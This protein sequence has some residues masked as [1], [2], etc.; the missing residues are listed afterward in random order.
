MTW[1]IIF[2]KILIVG[3]VVPDNIVLWDHYMMHEALI[4]ISCV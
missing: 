1:K 3:F 4:T 2:V